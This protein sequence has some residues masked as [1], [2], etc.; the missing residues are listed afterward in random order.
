M[1]YILIAISVI[2]VLLLI[3]VIRNQSNTRIEFDAS[4]MLLKVKDM[5]E[6]NEKLFQVV[7]KSNTD[8]IR[9][10]LRANID[11]QTKQLQ[12]VAKQI[13]TLT[14]INNQK[15][16]NV[17]GSVERN[18]K[19]LQDGNE[20]KL[21]QM[22]NTVDEKLNSTLERR[23]NESFALISKNLDAVQ[24]GLGEMRSLANGVGDLKK[25]LSNVKTRGTLAEVQLDSL[26]E[27]ILA[28][29]QYEKQVCVKKDGK[30]REDKVDFAIKL[31]G[32]DGEYVYLPI[33]A[34][35]PLEDYQ[36]LVNASEL[37]DI[38]EVAK[39]SK[40][41]ENAIKKEAISISSKYINPPNTTDFAVMYLALEGLYAEVVRKPGLLESLSQNQKII[42]C[43]PS[44]LSGLLNSLQMGFRTLA[45][46]KRS[47]E[48]WSMLSMFKKEF[49]TFIELLGK[50]QKQI[51]TA[52]NTIEEATRKSRIIAKKLNRVVI[53]DGEPISLLDD[54]DED[55]NA[56][57]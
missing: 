26:L 2:V 24:S 32:K 37:N 17:V 52:G 20:K 50:T 29:E 14:N 33:D 8:S 13:E 44:T 45:I 12:F 56:V 21:E 42:I 53:L 39:C 15:L 40:A 5:M 1:E 31:P 19:N 16:E 10:D 51:N 23:L 25:V 46:E 38:E 43:G 28:T 41:L 47:S 36:R 49:G 57:E 27:Q 7:S 18:L 6:Q 55:I 54:V 34:K 4:E 30:T 3:I 22:R 11:Y 9:N 35:F 48:I